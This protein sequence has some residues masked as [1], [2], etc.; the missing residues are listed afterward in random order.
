M[1]NKR[2]LLAVQQRVQ[3]SLFRNLTINKK[4]LNNNEQSITNA[5]RKKKRAQLL[6]HANKLMLF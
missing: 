1:N 3:R 5:L 4:L 6:N 2:N